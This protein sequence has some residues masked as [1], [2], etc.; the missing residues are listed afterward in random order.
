MKKILI[1]TPIPIWHP[2][3]KELVELLNK[4][5]F[6]VELLDVFNGFFI[7]NTENIKRIIKL[8]KQDDIILFGPRGAGKSTLL[9]NL[10]SSRRIS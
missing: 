3:T 5:N 8:S 9:K 10:F 6:N 2:G 1:L 7:M 4:N